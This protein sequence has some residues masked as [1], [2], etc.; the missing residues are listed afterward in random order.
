LTPTLFTSF[1]RSKRHFAKKTA[2]ARKKRFRPAF[3]QRAKTIENT[4][5]FHRKNGFFQE[6]STFFTENRIF[7]RFSA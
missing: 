2:D 1:L 7:F 5:D 6:K 4:P 3:L